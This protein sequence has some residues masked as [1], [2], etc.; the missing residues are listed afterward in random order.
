MRGEGATDTTSTNTARRLGASGGVGGCDV[1]TVH[2]D[3]D[4]VVRAVEQGGLVKRDIVRIV[5]RIPPY[6]PSI[7]CANRRR[8]IP[9]KGTR[10]TP[11]KSTGTKPNKKNKQTH[12]PSSTQNPTQQKNKINHTHNAQEYHQSNY[13]TTN[14][15]QPPYP[16]PTVDPLTGAATLI[17]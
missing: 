11:T 5:G 4:V 17:C 16:A 10:A 15:M 2:D 1:R 12:Q 14:P 8:T 9:T 6:C 7:A 3:L 13:S